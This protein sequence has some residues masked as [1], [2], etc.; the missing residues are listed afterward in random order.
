MSE[1]II[2]DDTPKSLFTPELK[3]KRV[4]REGKKNGFCCGGA[5]L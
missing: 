4:I 2:R 1:T 3:G 5:I